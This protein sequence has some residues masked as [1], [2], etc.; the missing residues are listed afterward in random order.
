MVC[1]PLHNCQRMFFFRLL[2][3]DSL[4][5]KSRMARAGV[6]KIGSEAV[7]TPLPLAC[8][9]CPLLEAEEMPC[10]RKSECAAAEGAAP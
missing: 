6:C 2:R 9:S 5:I 1:V 7:G 3:V 10:S 8:P 4:D